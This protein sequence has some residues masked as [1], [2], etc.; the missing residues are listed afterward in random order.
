[1]NFTLKY[2]IETRM[3][4]WDIKL[5]D[6]MYKW[7]VTLEDGLNDLIGLISVL[8]S[9]TNEVKKIRDEE[10]TFAGWLQSLRN[11][12][13]EHPQCRSYQVDLEGVEFADTWEKLMEGGDDGQKV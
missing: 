4:R 13:P 6:A 7:E 8:E 1:M 5:D 2:N 3:V 10:R 9:F 12:P 11:K